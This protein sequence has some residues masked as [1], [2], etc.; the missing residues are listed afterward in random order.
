MHNK[1]N[2]MNHEK[3]PGINRPRAELM[4]DQTAYHQIE[5][6]KHQ[7]FDATLLAGTILGTIAFLLGPDV[8]G[9]WYHNFDYL[10]DIIFLAILLV[11]SMLR[12][13]I[14]I[15]IKSVLVIFLLFGFFISDL[16]AF[17]VYSF[18]KVLIVVIPFYAMIVFSFRSTIILYILA[19]VIFLSIGY[20]YIHNYI[21]APQNMIAR[22]RQPDVWIESILIL[23][24]VALVIFILNRKY[25]Q[26]FSE[27]IYDLVH[28]N[29][30]LATRDAKLKSEKDFTDKLLNIIPGIFYLYR[31]NQQGYKLVRWNKPA[32]TRFGYTSDELKTMRPEDFFSQDYHELISKELRVVETEGFGNA[33]MPIMTKNGEGPWYYF[34]GHSFSHE[35]KELLSGD[36]P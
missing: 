13:R 27:L 19:V 22:M 35:K 2:R 10:T 15:K 7:I 4:S 12:K 1:T 5:K 32:E 33:E 9:E 20:L 8:R 36:R 28:K 3:V 16:L 17:G 30:V 23:T 11:V 18:D 24:M 26:T 29:K 25:N 34:E 14:P 31:K 21:E 6:I